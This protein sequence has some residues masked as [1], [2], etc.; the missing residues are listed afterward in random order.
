MHGPPSPQ[1]A[2]PK[3][4]FKAE[5][6]EDFKMV[7][8][9]QQSNWGALLGTGS[10]APVGAGA[11]CPESEEGR[12]L[13]LHENVALDAAARTAG[14]LCLGT[15]GAKTCRGITGPVLLS[16]SSWKGRGGVFEVPWAVDKKCDLGGGPDLRD[17]C[18][19]VWREQSR[20]GSCG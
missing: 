17:S 15:Q 13:G 1:A 12:L 5:V 16:E 2:L 20:R 19:R 6:V 3:H 10:R 9:A 14:R 18:L 8:L 4:R 7:S 11:V